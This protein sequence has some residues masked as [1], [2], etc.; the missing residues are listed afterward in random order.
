MK[1]VES[2]S[3]CINEIHQKWDDIKENLLKGEQ[4]LSESGQI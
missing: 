4:K 1:V 3:K 2:I